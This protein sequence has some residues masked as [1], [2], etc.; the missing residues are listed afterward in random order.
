MFGN[1]PLAES[2]LVAQNIA[3][4]PQYVHYLKLLKFNPCK[5]DCCICQTKATEI[6]YSFYEYLNS[7]KRN[8]SMHIFCTIYRT[9]CFL[10]I[11][12]IY[13]FMQILSCVKSRPKISR[14][15]DA[16]I[17]LKYI[18]TSIYAI[19]INYLHQQ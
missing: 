18:I 19:I 10:I 12:E 7:N 5:K 17:A 6:L 1:F 14:Y 2:A 16:W 3:T 13:Y 15:K 4:C 11:K 9:N 8:F